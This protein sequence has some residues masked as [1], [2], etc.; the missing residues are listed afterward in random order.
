MVSCSAT[1]SHHTYIMINLFTISHSLSLSQPTGNFYARSN[2]QSGKHTEK[3][4]VCVLAFTLLGT[5]S[6][7]LWHFSFCFRCGELLCV[8]RGKFVDICF[9]T[10]IKFYCTSYRR[11]RTTSGG[12]AEVWEGKI[13]WEKVLDFFLHVSANKM[14][15]LE[16]GKMAFIRSDVNFSKRLLSLVQ[17]QCKKYRKLGFDVLH[18]SKWF[19]YDV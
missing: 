18:T 3:L 1:H 13:S 2:G 10:E 15:T 16:S 14:A 4:C 6:T 5:I 9:S 17:T 11:T 19:E 12:R 7:V 8:R